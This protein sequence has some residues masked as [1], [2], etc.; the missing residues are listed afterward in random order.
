MASGIACGRKHVTTTTVTTTELYN[1]PAILQLIGCLQVYS[2]LKNKVYTD[3]VTSITRP[4]CRLN[5]RAHQ[6]HMLFWSW[7][8]TKCWFSIIES[9]AHV[10]LTFCNQGQVWPVKSLTQDRSPSLGACNS[11]TKP[12]S[13]HFYRPVYLSTCFLRNRSIQLYVSAHW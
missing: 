4:Y 5:F 10:R 3:H 9:Q 7:L 6:D 2:I 8:L 12:M 1:M 13:W 11:H